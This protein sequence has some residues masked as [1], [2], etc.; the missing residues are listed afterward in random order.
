MENRTIEE[1]RLHELV[2]R[3]LMDEDFRFVKIPK[4][5]VVDGKKRLYQEKGKT[6]YSLSELQ[7]WISD[8]NHVGIWGWYGKIAVVDLDHPNRDTRHAMLKAIVTQCGKTW[9]VKSC[10]GKEHLYYYVDRECHPEMNIDGDPNK[11]KAWEIRAKH[12]KLTL[13]P[14]NNH[15]LYKTFWDHGIATTTMDQ[16]LYALRPWTWENQVTLENITATESDSSGNKYNGDDINE[17]ISFDLFLSH[18]G[19]TIK[20]FVCPQ[21]HNI[22]SQ[23]QSK[24]ALQYYDDHIS[25]FRCGGGKKAKRWD[26]WSMLEYAGCVDKK[27]Q[28]K[29]LYE[30]AGLEWH[31]LPPEKGF[32]NAWLVPSAGMTV[33]HLEATGQKDEKNENSDPSFMFYTGAEIMLMD[34]PPRKFYLEII[35]QGSIININGESGVGKTLFTMSI[36]SCLSYGLGFMHWNNYTG[37]EWVDGGWRWHGNSSDQRHP[38]KVAYVDGE[39]SIHDVLERIP[40]FNLDRLFITNRFF[41][42]EKRL[43]LTIEK[44]RKDMTEWLVSNEI[45]LVVF[46]NVSSLCPYLDENSKKD[47]DAINQWTLE[48]RDK[49]NLTVI[50][51]HHTRKDGRE[52]SGTTGR[53]R[54][55][56]GIWYVNYPSNYDRDRDGVK[57]VL[58]FRKNRQ[59]VK[60]RKNPYASVTLELDDNGRWVQDKAGNGMVY[61]LYYLSKNLPYRVIAKKMKDRGYTGYSTSMLGDKRLTL[62]DN[63]WIDNDGNLTDKGQHWIDNHITPEDL[64]DTI[65]LSSSSVSISITSG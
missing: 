44:D 42:P 43:D 8:G 19:M 32:D 12:D 55:V 48:L 20:T 14:I 34:I 51:V 37:A 49:Y 4:L 13:V 59:K 26:M 63:G 62:I 22:S 28:L 7:G 46:D 33:Q 31:E 21:C 17:K 16:I 57:L 9:I 47:W 53:D 50:W 10:S 5:E 60:S 54:N 58:S 24:P 45:N 40:D 27:E 52:Q 64:V 29:T 30:I 36:C 11:D 38:I 39:M 6:P 65:S 35:P 2:P 18:Y 25:C 3:Q 61:L 56:D 15:G 23:G 41:T 1:R